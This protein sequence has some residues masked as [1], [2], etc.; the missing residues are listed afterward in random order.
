MGVETQGLV[1]FTF[2][3]FVWLQFEWFDV[4]SSSSSSVPLG[5]L[6]VQTCE[7]TVLLDESFH[8]QCGTESLKRRRS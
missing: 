1:N 6:L 5:S 8:Y 3:F 7:P 2:L 4:K